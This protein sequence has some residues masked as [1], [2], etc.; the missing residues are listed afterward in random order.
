MSTRIPSEHFSN[1]ILFY[2]TAIAISPEGVG[3]VARENFSFFFLELFKTPDDTKSM[4]MVWRKWELSQKKEW[5][6][7]QGENDISKEEK[8]RLMGIARVVVQMVE[9]REIVKK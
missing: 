1:S 3:G 5:E 6:V 4:E 7:V 8:G 9:L 2:T